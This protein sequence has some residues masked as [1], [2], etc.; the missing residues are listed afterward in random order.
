[1]HA[2][3]EPEARVCEDPRMTIPRVPSVRA[4]ARGWVFAACWIAS[5]AAAESEAERAAL[6]LAL[7]PGMTVAEVGAGDGDFTFEFARR[8]G[9]D[10]RVYATEI[11]AEKRDAIAAEAT[12]RG[13]ANVTVLEAQVASTGLPAGCCRAAF[14]RHVY[15]HLTE[16][17]ALD[18]DLLRA[19]EPGALF[20]VVD[21]PPTWFL[22]PFA[23][24]GVGEE[25]TEHGIEIDAALREL[26]SA[27]F[28]QVR[29]IPDWETHWFGPDGYAL[30]LRKPRGP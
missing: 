30:L 22:I 4:R 26:T 1:L 16:P 24:D 25:R 23:P 17:A 21:F 7:E 15:H 27:G 18:A 8:V 11:E 5:S 10:G 13:L 9:P 14:M 3:R 28:E 12:A 6:L 29:V 19:L 20:L 2:G